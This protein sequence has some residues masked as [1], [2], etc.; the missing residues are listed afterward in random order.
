M[1]EEIISF[2]FGVITGIV[3]EYLYF[4][5]KNKKHIT[6]AIVEEKKE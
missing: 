3:V 4:I 6:Q 1:I 5:N 2:V